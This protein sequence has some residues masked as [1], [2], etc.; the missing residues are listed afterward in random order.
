MNLTGTYQ[1]RIEPLPRGKLGKFSLSHS[2]EDSKRT[3]IVA[4]EAPKSDCLAILS[5]RSARIDL[6]VSIDRCIQGKLVG[7]IASHGSGIADRFKTSRNKA[8]RYYRRRS[9][10]NVSI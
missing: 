9:I 2:L 7:I 10:Q 8:V 6:G 1:G 5:P 4:E 3:G